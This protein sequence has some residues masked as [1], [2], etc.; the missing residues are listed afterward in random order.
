MSDENIGGFFSYDGMYK[1]ED[2]ESWKP[3]N[4]HAKALYKK[5]IDI[6]NFTQTMCDM[7]PDD[8]HATDTKSL[9][10][11]NAMLISAK[12]AGA[13]GM[14]LYSLMMESAVIIKVNVTQLRDQLWACKTFHNIE[15]QYID[16]L[17]NEIDEFRKIFIS[18][19]TS[20]DKENDVP[21]E[22]HLFNDP[23]SFPDE[24]Q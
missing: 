10:M 9:M 5:G 24:E 7:L 6:L 11:Q 8:D 21:D 12:I 2:N 1:G 18:W 13:K 3:V 16:V 4:Q 17:R 19:V 23:A 20:F 15:Q 14:E 22:W